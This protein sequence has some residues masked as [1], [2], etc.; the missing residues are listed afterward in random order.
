MH[1]LQAYSPVVL[2]YSQSCVVITTPQ[3]LNISISPEIN[4]VL[5][6]SHSLFPL[7]SKIFMTGLFI[8]LPTGRTPI[9]T[10]VHT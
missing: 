4:P 10:P 5:L 9:I 8:F 6:S 3:F 1:T 2:A 7:P